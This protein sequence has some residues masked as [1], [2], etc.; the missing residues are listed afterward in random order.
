MNFT[1]TSNFSSIVFWSFYSDLCYELKLKFA[2]QCLFYL[3]E[4]RENSV[5]VWDDW[6]LGSQ[7][8]IDNWKDHV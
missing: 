4:D 6:I 5:N 1:V 7:F 8:W 3:Q 2:D